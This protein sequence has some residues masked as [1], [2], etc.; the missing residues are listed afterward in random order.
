LAKEPTHLSNQEA[1]NSV[2]PTATE[3]ES[4]SILARKS[5]DNLYQPVIDPFSDNPTKNNKS[6]EDKLASARTHSI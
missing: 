3:G 4:D 1:A 5:H 6:G 2:S